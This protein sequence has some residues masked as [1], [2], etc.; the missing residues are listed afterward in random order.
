MNHLKVTGDLD[1][2]DVKHFNHTRD[3]KKAPQFLN[4]QDPKELV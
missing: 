4:E 3:S 2:I 1:L